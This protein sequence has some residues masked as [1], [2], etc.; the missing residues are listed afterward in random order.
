[1]VRSWRWPCSSVRTIKK[2]KKNPSLLNQGIWQQEK[3]PEF[4][5]TKV[6]STKLGACVQNSINKFHKV[7]QNLLTYNEE[8]AMSKISNQTCVD[9]LV[10]SFQHLHPQIGVKQSLPLPQYDHYEQ[11]A[12]QKLQVRISYFSRTFQIINL[13]S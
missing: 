13:V 10:S 7:H 2:N 8:E 5:M 12:I 3:Q 1:M 9:H 4:S 11:P 6:T